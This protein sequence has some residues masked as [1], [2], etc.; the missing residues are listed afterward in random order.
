MRNVKSDD[1]KEIPT[2]S[3]HGGAIYDKTSTNG[4][5]SQ[6]QRATMKRRKRKANCVNY[7]VRNL[8]IYF[9]LQI[10]FHEIFHFGN[11]D[12]GCV[13]VK[14]A[15]PTDKKRSYLTACNISRRKQKKIWKKPFSG[16]QMRC[17]K[18]VRTG[19]IIF[20]QFTHSSLFF[21]NTSSHCWFCFQFS[22]S[23]LFFK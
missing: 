22:S 18:C 7:S 3:Q 14:R 4:S 6:W 11:D 17:I 2:C 16:L 9:T 13:S 23:R 12:R 20:T 10:G 8:F 1:K 21:S 19:Y 15:I 5:Q